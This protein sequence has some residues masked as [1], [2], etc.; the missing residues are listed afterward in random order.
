MLLCLPK[1]QVGQPIRFKSLSVFPLFLASPGKLE[2]KLAHE[3]LADKSVVVQEV[4]EQGSVSNLLVINHNNVP[5]FFLEGEELVGAKQNRILNTSVL[6]GPRCN[7]VIPVS[8]V[9]ARRWRYH[10]NFFGT[11]GSTSPAKLR[12]ALKAS[13]YKSTQ[14]DGTHQSDQPEIWK[15][16]ADLHAMHGVQ[17]DTAAMSDA[18]V[19]HHQPLDEYRNALKPVEGAA[20]MAVC[21]GSQ[22]KAIDIFDKADTCERMWE[23][24][25]SGIFFD[26]IAAPDLEASSS[27]EDVERFISGLRDQKWQSVKAVGEGS[28]F[29]TETPRGDL[30][31]ALEVDGEVL[32]GNVL[33]AK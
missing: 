17:S 12:R 1:S 32:H 21:V 9:E 7:T 8:C 33:A 4:D 20:G 26:A 19:A 27:V 11:S 25:L 24:V 16:V 18:F 6:V 30:A 23:R 13:V 10:S 15:E 2:Y 22:I 14:K 29:R 5:V 31:F 28:E 3:A